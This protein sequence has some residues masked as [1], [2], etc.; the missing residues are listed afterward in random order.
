MPSPITNS[1]VLVT[2]ATGFIAA[3]IVKQLLAI[4]YRVRGTTRDV[5]VCVND[6]F[7]TALPGAPERLDLFEADL[8]DPGAF[9]E[10][11]TGCEYVMHTASP[12]IIEFDDPQKDLVEPALNGTLSVLEACARTGQVKRVV[13]TSSFAAV[14]G[15]PADKVFDESS[16]NTTSNLDRGAYA[17]SKTLAEKAAWKF[18]EDNDTTFDLVVINPTGVIGPSIVPRLNT[19]HGFF[20]AMAKGEYPG[21]IALD[22]PFVDVRDIARAHILAMENPDAAGRYITSNTNLSFRQIVEYSEEAGLGD[23]Y[24]LPTMSLD[25]ALGNVLVRFAANFQPQGVKDFLKTNVG[26][27]YELDT[28]KVRND[29]GLEFIDIKTS[30]FDAVE[31]LQQW[32]HI[33][34]V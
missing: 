28:S 26:H 29:L 22:F 4:G 33:A 18:V 19:T 31:D 9:D 12:F 5:D 34:P 8:L 1:P 30:V 14:S 7:L 32:G 21:I 16:W 23:E 11:V 15:G 17:Y 27:T 10:A 3:E 20:V 2:G 25:N 13:L 6:G 24:K